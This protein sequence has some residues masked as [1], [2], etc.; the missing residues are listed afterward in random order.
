MRR[1]VDHAF[2][3]VPFYRER[4]EAAGYEVGML[5]T[6]AD[7]RAL[8]IVSKADLLGEPRERLVSE[9]VPHQRLLPSVTSG[10]SGELLTV[11]HDA[12]R[13]GRLGLGILRVSRLVTP[14]RPWDRTLYIYTSEFPVRSVFGLYPMTYISTTAALDDIVAVWRRTNPGFVWIYPSRLRDLIAAGK[15][16]PKTR[17]ISVGS[18]MSTAAERAS[19]EAELGSPVR[20][21]YATEEL[22]IVAAECG[23]LSRHV[24]TDLCFIEILDTRGAAAPP[25]EVGEV[26]GTN[27]ENLATPIIRYQQGDRAALAPSACTCGRTLPILQSLEGRARIDLRTVTGTRVSSGVVIDT[28]YGLALELGLSISG[29]QLIDG[30]PPLLLLEGKLSDREVDSAV[31]FVAQRAELMVTALTVDFLPNGAGGKREMIVARPSEPVGGEIGGV[32]AQ[33]SDD[34]DREES[35][36]PSTHLP[37]QNM[38]DGAVGEGN[39]ND[40]QGPRGNTPQQDDQ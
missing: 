38:P 28:M 27:L 7:V 24:F 17:L 15:Q 5:R 2:R 32:E 14:H 30:D 1:V 6:M 11:W 35:T 33:P 9:A 4:Y 8:P 21:Q 31:A 10:T 13:L 22:G 19:W 40:P 23:H 39:G 29:Y 3:T 20:D 37:S 34:I 18:E 12:A 26:V 16:V 36:R 25:G